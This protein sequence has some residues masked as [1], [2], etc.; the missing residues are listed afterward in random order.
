MSKAVPESW[1]KNVFQQTRKGYSD[2]DIFNAD[3]TGIFYKMTYDKTMRFKGEKCSG[4]KMSKDRITV[5]VAANMRG[6]EKRKLLV[7]G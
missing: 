4:G 1:L 2:D 5:M 6:I 3:E 7:I